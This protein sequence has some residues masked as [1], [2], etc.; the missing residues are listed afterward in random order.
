MIS[1]TLEALIFD[2]DG[3]LADTER[4][5]HRV[6]YNAAFCEFGLDWEWNPEL[7]GKLLA[8]HGGKERLHYYLE[9]YR[10]ES[11]TNQ[12]LEDYIDELHDLKTKRFVEIVH[13]RGIPARPGIRRLLLEARGV[14]LRLAI[15]T[16]T[17]RANV[18]ALLTTAIDPGAVDWFETIAAGEDAKNKKPAPDIY[19]LVLEKMQLPAE[20]A[21]AFEDSH[22]GLLSATN[23]GIRTVVTVNHYTDGE[24]FSRA[25][26]VVNHLGEPKLGSRVLAANI[27]LSEYSYINVA[28]LYYL[29]AHT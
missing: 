19:N 20:R 10:P 23:A 25:V 8:I 16:T 21:L 6:A 9:N 14:G 3:T 15:A 27:P 5:G 13:Q 29:H 22:N 1:S 26:L 18:V 12:S 24:D 11:Q 17:A 7:Y 4:D 2:V 28:C